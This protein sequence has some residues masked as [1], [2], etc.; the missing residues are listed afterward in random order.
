MHNRARHSWYHSGSKIVWWR[1]PSP[2]TPPSMLKERPHNLFQEVDSS[3]IC[4][5]RTPVDVLICLPGVLLG[6]EDL[7]PQKL[8]ILLNDG[9]Q[10]LSSERYSP[11]ERMTLSK[12]VLPYQDPL[13]PTVG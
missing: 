9:T 2:L 3:S 13:H 12:M 11:Y 4:K 10:H 1:L 8:R 6:L 7:F 5:L